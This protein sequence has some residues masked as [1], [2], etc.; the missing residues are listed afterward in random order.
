MNGDISKTLETFSSK[1]KDLYYRKGDIVIR[2]DDEPTGVYMLK[3]GNVKMSFIN[4]DGEELAVNLFKPG[5]FFPMSWAI[6]DVGNNYY[7]QT[8]T[9]S[10]VVRVPKEEFVDFLRKNPEVLFDLTRRIL[11]GL[12][13]LL[14]NVRHLLGSNSISKIAVI[15]FTFAKR[16]GV[17]KG[18]QI[19]INL[20]ITHQEIA[21]FA[22]VSRETATI[23][24][25]K[26][27]KEG[28]IAQK[29]RR[30]V[31][32]NLDVLEKYF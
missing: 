19:E 28:V 17:K 5:T 4:E 12:D 22:G 25:N 15:I 29:Q 8:L 11:V 23:A 26:L 14:F 18:N 24:I 16:F 21:H 31:I 32:K 6:G 30:L 7:Y 13:G 1:Y 9:A 10:N 3:S 20:N 2:G 27:E